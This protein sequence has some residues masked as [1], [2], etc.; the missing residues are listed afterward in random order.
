MKAVDTIQWKTL[1]QLN[2]EDLKKL[3]SRVNWRYLAPIVLSIIFGLLILYTI[4][5]TASFFLAPSA[6][7]QQTNISNSDKSSY[8][9]IKQIPQWHLYGL[10]LNSNVAPITSLSLSLNGIIIDDH[11]YN[12]VAFIAPTQNQDDEKAYHINDMLPDGAKVYAIRSNGIIIQYMGH[13]ERLPLLV[14]NVDNTA[15]QNTPVT[16]EQPTL[17]DDTDNNPALVPYK[18][19]MGQEMQLLRR[20]RLGQ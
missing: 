4:T 14:E 9:M 2:A 12:S 6:T 15:Q 16:V 20:F 10:S 18:N 17:P 5:N 3:A 1:T 11:A 7:T 8:S 13:L 19:L